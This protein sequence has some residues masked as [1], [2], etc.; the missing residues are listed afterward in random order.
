MNA[1]IHHFLYDFKTGIRERSK[2]LMYYLFPLVFFV[3]VGGLLTSVNPYFKDTML[4]AMLLF[5]YMCPTLQ[6]FPNALVS[7]RETG[8]FR[9]YRINGVPAA[10]IVSVPV[11]SAAL[12]MALLSVILAVAGARVFGGAM[13]DHVGGFILVSALSY[14][15]YAGIGVLVGIA[16]GSGTAATLVCQIIYIPSI[17]LGGLMVPISIM[18]AAL[19]H[20]A[21]LLPA[22][23]CMRLFSWLAMPGAGSPQWLSLGVL[24]ASTVLSFL[25]AGLLFQWESRANAP[26]KKPW[27]A[28][29]VVVPFAIAA[30]AG[31]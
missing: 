12:H 3:L 24:L 11:L 27:L 2:L 18:P 28:L 30:V 17:I 29:L 31:A 21:M 5:G 7:A 26:T 14:F 9:S 19:Q 13:P 15:S 4:P 23:H 8:V 6:L 20:V 1:Y 25:L 10:S 22:T 16:C